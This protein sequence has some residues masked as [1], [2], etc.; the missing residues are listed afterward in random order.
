MKK[1]ILE[2][3]GV[4]IEEIGWREHGRCCRE[5]RGWGSDLMMS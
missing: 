1:R 3:V 5:E 4:V 2:N